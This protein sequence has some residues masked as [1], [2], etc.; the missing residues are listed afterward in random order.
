MLDVNLFDYGLPRELIAQ[1]PAERRDESRLFVVRRSTGAFEHRRFRDVVEYLNPGDLIVVN[2]TRVFPARLIGFRPATGGKVEVLL[3]R[4]QPAVGNREVAGQTAEPA[5]TL[6]GDPQFSSV[7]PRS[8]RWLCLVRAR[9]RLR[10]GEVIE[11]TGGL[12][13][14]FLSGGAAGEAIVEFGLPAAELLR[15]VE[16]IGYPPL[17]PYIKRSYPTPPGPVPGPG[18]IHA[19]D[20]ERYQTIYARKSG[21][22][23]A[24]TAGLHFTE[25][26]L[27]RLRTKGIRTAAITLHVGPGTFKPV[28]T[29]K[30]E[31]H[32]MDP[33]YY[34]ITPTVV[35]AIH[36][37]RKACKRVVAVGTTTVRALETAARR[38]GSGS[39]LS[40]WTDLF[41]Y[42]PYEFRSVDALITNF[43]LPRSTLLML[44]SAFATRELILRAYA[45][46]VRLRY[47]FYSY[48][49]AMLIL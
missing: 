27:D 14:T 4:E 42:P 19:R 11:F 9:G 30:V 25:E 40:G 33:E 45:E 16:G 24:P 35:E 18:D 43:H 17:P 47:R 32:K 15:I 39:Q 41:I 10:G 12:R 6:R 48:G 29:G 20:R 44:V 5:E 13:A 31:M 46:A 2:D 34:E 22:V 7:S 37:T 21:A 28:K 38:L 49:D 8:T 36:A 3:V 23:A 26:L 1:E